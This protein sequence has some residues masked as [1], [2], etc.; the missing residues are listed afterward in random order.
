MGR[1]LGGN[2]TSL[3]GANM[4]AALHLHIEEFQVLAG[5]GYF[6][7]RRGEVEPVI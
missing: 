4:W 7:I 6:L 5:Y 1:G 2:C 3:A